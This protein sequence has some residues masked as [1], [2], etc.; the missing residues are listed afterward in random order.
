MTD[1]KPPL[2]GMTIDCDDPLP[3]AEFWQEFLGYERRPDQPHETDGRYITL[4]KPSGVPGLHH[5]TFQ[6]VP[7]PKAGKARGHLDLFV[8]H[9]EPILRRMLEAGATEIERHGEGSG[10]NRVLLDP[11]GNEFCLIGPD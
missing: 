3:L 5:V 8:E 10:V 6:S 7:E 2:I 1:P 9:A 4:F 11:A